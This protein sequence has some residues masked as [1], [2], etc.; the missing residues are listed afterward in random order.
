MTVYSHG[1]QCIIPKPQRARTTGGVND[2]I[3]TYIFAGS[4]LLPRSYVVS[5]TEA[6][7]VIHQVTPLDP[8]NK[9]CRH[10]LCHATYLLFFVCGFRAR[11]NEENISNRIDSNRLFLVNRLEVSYDWSKNESP[12]RHLSIG[13]R[14]IDGKSIRSN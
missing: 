7:P 4:V 13:A 8:Q 11:I 12:R 2:A 5:C 3:N 1:E 14:E 10:F 6:T 9:A